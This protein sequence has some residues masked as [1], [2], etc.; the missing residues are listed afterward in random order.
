MYND[1]CINPNVLGDT[2]DINVSVK[3][4]VKVNL[5]ETG[6]RTFNTFFGYLS[7][8]QQVPRD[9]FPTLEKTDDGFY[10]MPFW[11]FVSVFGGPIIRSED[12][13][14]RYYEGDVLLTS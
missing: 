8:K 3:T 11:Q 6:V 7:D 9:E 5:T 13:L 14:H 4:L 1:T 12:D 2:M 10:Q